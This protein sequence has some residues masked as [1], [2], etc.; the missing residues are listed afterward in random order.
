MTQDSSL[1]F[2]PSDCFKSDFTSTRRVSDDLS[3]PFTTSQ[4]RANAGLNAAASAFQPSMPDRREAKSA[5]ADKFGVNYLEGVIA[6]N[7]ERTP[8]EL[9]RSGTFTH[10]AFKSRVLKV[11]CITEGSAVASIENY[12]KVSECLHEIDQSD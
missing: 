11:T 1:M 9:S 4:P 7:Q 2:S 12:V 8:D 3:D 6:N 5:A 10:D